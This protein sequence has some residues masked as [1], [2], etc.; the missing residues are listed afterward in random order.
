MNKCFILIF[1]IL[2]G[3]VSVFSQTKQQGSPVKWELYS[4]SSKKVSV[5]L[6]KMPVRISKEDICFQLRTDTYAVYADD[7][8]FGLSIYSKMSENIPK[9]CSRKRKFDAESFQFRLN[10][11]KTQLKT[12]ESKNITFNNNKAEFIKDDIYNYWLINDFKNNQWVELWTANSA[13]TTVEVKKFINSLKISEIKKGIEINK[14]ADSNTGGLSQGFS[15]KE[16]SKN[17]LEENKVEDSKIY[18]VIKP[19]PKYTDIAREKN[20]QG[21]V[22][23]RITFL[24]NGGIGSISPVRGVGDGLTEEAIA[25]A[26]KIV[27]I[28]A[29]RNGKNASVTMSVQYTFTIY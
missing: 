1:I 15:E 19:Q 3:S 18:F 4:V 27:F 11:L 5:L 23:L 13:G 17:S 22:V 12:S 24:W 7:V 29:K 21:Q 8:I 2:F 9:S 20:T 6:P 14:G 10:E 26:K 16:K 25:A 28:P